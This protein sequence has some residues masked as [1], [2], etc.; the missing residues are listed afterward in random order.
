[1]RKFYGNRIKKLVDNNIGGQ[2]IGESAQYGGQFIR[3]S[4]QYGR[5]AMLESDQCW[6]QATAGVR[7]KAESDQTGS[8]GEQDKRGPRTNG[9]PSSLPNLNIRIAGV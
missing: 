5:A 9:A 6:S 4:A 1:L 7:P 3:E 8:Q 2:L